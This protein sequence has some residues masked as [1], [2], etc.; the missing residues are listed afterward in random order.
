MF[1]SYIIPIN[2]NFQPKSKNI[3]NFAVTFNI[4][5][6]WC[7]I[8]QCDMFCFDSQ[9][10]ES[11]IDRNTYI[12][13]FHL[14]GSED[15]VPHFTDNIHQEEKLS[16]QNLPDI[17]QNK[18]M[19]ALSLPPPSRQDNS[20]GAMPRS[21]V[22]EG[23]TD[24]NQAFDTRPMGPP[25]QQQPLVNTSNVPQQK[26]KSKNPLKYFLQTRKEKYDTPKNKPPA[27]ST[28]GNMTGTQKV[29]LVA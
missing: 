21:P 10:K 2:P 13:P 5:G 27:R 15:N 4:F 14:G 6:P 28:P 3:S 16:V 9:K 11:Q 25:Y 12:E 20:Y 24:Q 23:A 17:S 26:K 7:L 29:D 1:Y 19:P 22:V 18:R 8:W